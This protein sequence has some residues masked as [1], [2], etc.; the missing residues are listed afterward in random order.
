[1]PR[2]SFYVYRW[3]REDT[4]TPF[5]VG[6]GCGKRAIITAGR[7]D[8]FNKIMGATQCRVEIVLDG[9]DSH[10][11]FQKEV[12]FIAMYRRMGYC[13]ANFTGGGD[14]QSNILP[15]TRRKISETLKRNPVR[16]NLGKKA[17]AETRAKQR[18]AKLGKPQSAQSNLKRSFALRGELSYRS[19]PVIC[20]ATGARYVSATE[21]AM[22]FGMARRTLCAQLSGQS[23]NKTTLMYEQEV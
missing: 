9:L 15:E 16:A 21:A 5:Y 22:A 3:V 2:Q 11:A 4:N 18:A 1:M 14:G 13:E 20:T 17:G 8:R 23:T 7:N 6:K 19:K 12:E 10:E